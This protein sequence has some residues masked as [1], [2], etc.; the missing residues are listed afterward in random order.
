MLRELRFAVRVLFKNPGFLFVAVCSLAIGIGANS[1]IYSFAYSVMLR[2][3]PVPK[4]SQVVSVTA[5]SGM[6]IFQSGELSYPDYVDLKDHNRTFEGLVASSYA[7]FGVAANKAVQPRRKFGAYVSGNFFSDLKLRPALGRSFRIAEDQVA[8]RDS[9]VMLSYEF[10][11][12]EFG[13]SVNAIGSK[14]WLNGTEFTVI[15]VAPKEF[16]A[17][18]QLKPALYVPLAMSP[19][20]SGENNL[21]RRDV[22]W[23]DVKGRLRPGTNMMQARADLNALQNALRSAY[24]KEESD[25]QIKVKTEFQLR[26]DRSPADTAL[27]VMLALLAL[28]VLAVACANVASLLLSRA[29][30][31]AREIGVRLAIGASRVSLIRQLLLENLILALA[32]A[33]AGLLIAVGATKFFNTI[34]LPTDVPIDL[35]VQLDQ[36]ALVVTL[37]I[38]VVSTFLFGFTPALRTTKVDLTQTLKDKDGAGKPRQRLWGRKMIVASQVALSLVLM[39]ISLALLDGFRSQLDQGPG[40]RVERLQL[41]S[42]DPGLLHYTEAQRD[43]FY[44]QLLDKVRVLPGVQSAT[45]SSAIPMSMSMLSTIGVVPEGY[46]LKKGE[47]SVDTFDSV[48]SPD[49]FNVMDIPL[50]KGRGFEERDKKDTTPVAIVNEQ[51]ALHYWPNQDGIGKQ[52]RLKDASSRPVTVIGVAKRSK[53]LWISESPIDF[54]YLPFSQNSQSTMALIAQS[55]SQDAASLIPRLRAVVQT[56]DRNMPLFEVR[57]MKS[58]YESRA[59]ATPKIITNTVAAMGLMGLILS[60][61]GLYGVVSYSVIRRSREFGIRMAVGAARHQVIGMVLRQGFTL[62]LAGLTVGLVVGIFAL[63][64]IVSTLLFSFPIQVWPFVAVGVLLLVTTVLA[65]YAPARRASL[66]DPVRALREE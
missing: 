45:L 16:E 42:F 46:Q 9:V 58:L 19:V 10:W 39:L 57:T 50:V 59:I 51:F 24:P 15:G 41:M 25:L 40:F 2:P 53:Y 5:V 8:G 64:A 38:A 1:A 65:A 21:V 43:V 28:C 31:R 4:P 26:A 17:L 27:L 33:A 30:V 3:L 44:K 47:S 13:T 22:R 7:S 56:I 35:T 37:I 60:V 52:I 61:I 23:L 11:A 20:L 29:T 18:E 34:P 54:V 63:R 32:G 49:Y 66:I 36:S 55:K 62:A 14:L 12:S 48:V 6:A